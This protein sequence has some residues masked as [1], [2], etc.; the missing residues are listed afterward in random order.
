MTNTAHRYRSLN[1]ATARARGMQADTFT[2]DELR[3]SLP[4][5]GTEGVLW[6]SIGTVRGRGEVFTTERV[7][8]GAEGIE[9]LGRFDGSPVGTTE[10]ICRYPWGAGRTLRILTR[11]P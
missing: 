8:N 9:V 4:A 5:D 10:V 3:A 1:L 2:V 7:R 6:R 11:K